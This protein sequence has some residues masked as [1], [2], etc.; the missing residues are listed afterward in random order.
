MI[1]AKPQRSDAKTNL[2]FS[3]KLLLITRPQ[4]ILAEVN[5]YSQ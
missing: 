3:N 5:L 4:L 2:L 1:A